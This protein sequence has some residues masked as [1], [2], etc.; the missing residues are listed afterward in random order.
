MVYSMINHLGRW[1]NTRRILSCSSNIPR[2]PSVHKSQK[3][4]VLCLNIIIANCR[5]YCFGLLG[6][7]MNTTHTHLRKAD[8]TTLNR[9]SSVFYQAT[10]KGNDKN[11]SEAYTGLTE[12]DFKTRYRN[13]IASFCHAKTQ[14][15]HRIQQI[16][17][18]S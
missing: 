8:T 2:G 14:E 6:L 12:S 9:Q 1:K 7:I 5:Q 18:D 17:L 10:V 11:T 4:V 16:Y 13:H 3:P 15:L